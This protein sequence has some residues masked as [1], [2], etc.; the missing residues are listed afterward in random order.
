MCI[1]ICEHG[2]AWQVANGTMKKKDRK[3]L[4][5]HFREALETLG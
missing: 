2:R 5:S 1:C 3:K 4:V